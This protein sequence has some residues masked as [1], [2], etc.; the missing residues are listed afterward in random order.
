VHPSA[1]LTDHRPH[2]DGLVAFGF[3]RE[4]AARGHE[5][6]IAA[7]EADLHQDLPASAHVHPLG[8][9]RGPA[10]LDRVSFMWRMRRLHRILH[11][12]AP[13]DVVHQL[14]PVEVGLTL[15]LAD[16][17]TP[18]VL[19]P[20]VPEWPGVR[21]PGGALMRP[22]VVRLNATIRAAQQRRAATVLLSTPAAASRIAVGIPGRAHVRLV[23]PGI[24]DRAWMPP[25]VG[26]PEPA[27]EVLFLANLTARKGILVLL[28]AFGRVARALPAA[29]LLV[30]GDGPLGDEVRRR[31]QRSGLAERVELLGAVERER[32]PELM[33]RCTVCCCP[34]L[35]EPFGMTALEAMACGKPVVA[36]D[37]GGLRHLVP[38]E[39]GRKVPPGDAVSLAA[40]LEEILGSVEL[41]RAMGSH[42]RRTVEERYAWARVVDKLE[43][44]Y[45]EAMT[46]PRTGD[47]G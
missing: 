14:N 35:G 13:F 30:A 33:Q 10:P 8:A 36:T 34:S 44:A 18:I 37:A 12:A 23:S 46:G 19:G 21:K 25:A 41:R 1:L 3:I 17:G 11:K 43:D 40:A 5:L 32:G 9:G 15:A 45:R 26:S 24:D 38:D 39:G 4:L 16:V 6:H 28:D 27:Q 7:E 31:V 22:L 29:R 20:Y 47:L 2:G 42:N